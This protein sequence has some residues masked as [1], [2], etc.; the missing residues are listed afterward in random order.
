MNQDNNGWKKVTKDTVLPERFLVIMRGCKYPII[1]IGC[2]VFGAGGFYKNEYG[3]RL[4]IERMVFYHEI[5]KLP[6]DLLEGL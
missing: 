3:N 2:S 6:I 4:Y 5:P 1:A